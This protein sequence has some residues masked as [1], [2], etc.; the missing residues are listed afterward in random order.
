[1]SIFT[2]RVTRTVPVPVD[3]DHTITIRQLSPKH[4]RAALAAKAADDMAQ[5]RALVQSAGRES[6]AAMKD[7]LPASGEENKNAAPARRGD[8][9]KAAGPA[10]YDRQTLLV[11]AITSWTYE[12]ALTPETIEEI[13]DDTQTYL[14]EQVLRLSKPSL[15][16][17]AEEMEADRGND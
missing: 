2:N 8:R 14:V 3:P 7:L 17:T 10:D 16:Q 5:A 13:D 6:I 1:M 11:S 9:S 12:E 4:L 15:F